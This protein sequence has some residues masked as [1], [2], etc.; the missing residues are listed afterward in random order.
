MS[1]TLYQRGKI[2]HYR[3]TIAGH[4]ISKSTGTS[5]R[6]IA[7]RIKAEA[8]TAAWRSHLDGPG[9]HVTFAQAATSYMDAEKPTRF[10]LKILDHWKETPIR[11][12]TAGAI[13]QSAI[14]LYP[15]AKGATRNRQAI[16]PTQA[17]LNFAAALNWCNPIK[18]ERFK[19]ETKV[20]QPATRAWV[21]AFADQAIADGLP[22]LGALCLFLFGTGAR[23]GEA[24]AIT[25]GAVDL[26][27]KT[28]LINQGKTLSERKSHMA[29]PVMAALA[30]IP[31]N[32]APDELVF[33]YL[34]GQNV[35]Q[36]WDAVIKRAK[37]ARLTPHSCRHGFATTMLRAGFDVKTVAKLGGW[38]D[39]ATVLKYYAHAL[40]DPTLT[41]AL[42]GTNLTQDTITKPAT[43]RKKRIK[44]Q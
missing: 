43:N 7:D 38:K 27:G 32:R 33:G 37:I 2:W 39:A 24:V 30:N 12:I 41:D 28:V 35:G 14:T 18:V 25:W 8:E 1:L 23:T 42:F 10:L 4:R 26:N 15:N 34:E 40:D 3:G 13:K 19:V 11:Q 20:K 29:A 5:D 36:T 16:V 6:K 9:A 21:L 22:H 44:S 31:S 17:I